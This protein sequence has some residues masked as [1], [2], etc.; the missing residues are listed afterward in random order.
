M[1]D[2]DKMIKMIKEGS[3]IIYLKENCIIFDYLELVQ[4]QGEFWTPLPYL[5]MCLFALIEVTAFLFIVPETKGKPMPDRM[6]GEEITSHETAK[7][8]IKI[9]KTKNDEHM[10]LNEFKK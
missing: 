6:P 7:P 1:I 10:P 4:F 5:T 9:D 2:A 3:L 8:L